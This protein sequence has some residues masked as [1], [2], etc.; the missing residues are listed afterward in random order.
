MIP[1][2]PRP[3]MGQTMTESLTPTQDKIKTISGVLDNFLAEVKKDREA[4]QSVLA[5]LA[6]EYEDLR[7]QLEEITAA[8]TKPVISLGLEKTG[9]PEK[10]WSWSRACEGVLAKWDTSKNARI[11]KYPEREYMI[12]ATRAAQAAGI[13]TQGGFLVPQEVFLDSIIPAL[14]AATVVLAAG[15]EFM[16]N[17]TGSPFLW[18]KLDSLSSGYWL[19]EG[20]SLT[21]DNLTFDMMSMEPHGCG[22][23]IP[24]TNQVIRQTS[25]R[26]S[27]AVRDQLVRGIARTTDLAYL[28]GTGG[29]Q[30]AGILNQ[31]DVQTVSFS[32]AST[33]TDN[34]HARIAVQS[35][36]ALL[37]KAEENNAAFDKPV[38]LMHP[39]TKRWFRAWPEATGSARPLFFSADESPVSQSTTMPVY[40]GQMYGHRYYCTTALTGNSA[41]A[42]LIAIQPSEI[43]VGQWGPM[44]LGASTEVR[45]LEN[46]T[47]I[48]AIV[49]VDVG[50]KHGKSVTYATGLDT[51]T[52]SI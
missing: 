40:S 34:A 28:K 46:Q 25:G 48:K 47:V 14:E 35:L 52:A 49:E 8:N 4:D 12:E 3:G 29:T 26:V 20:I 18:P 45:F 39:H 27:A 1:N 15:V 32:G 22:A 38:L 21:E 31:A 5:K 51:A 37:S 30:P 19:A 42:D 2:P 6:N 41:T 50:L 11:E 10:D 33:I 7:K 24:L 44:I 9:D 23:F 43:M 13:D 36:D 16:T 17:L